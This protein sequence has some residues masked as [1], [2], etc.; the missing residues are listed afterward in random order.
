MYA[1]VSAEPGE[2]T[3]L[4]SPRNSVEGH[5]S[6]LESTRCNVL[7][8]P[9][10]SKV[11]HIL[12]KRKMRHFNV[13]GLAE[14]LRG[15]FIEHYEY[16][17]TFEEAERDPFIVVHT[18]G[19]TGLPK[20][21]IFYLGGMATIDNQHGISSLDGFDAQIKISEGPVRVFTGLPPFHV[22]PRS[23]HKIVC[24]MSNR[25]EH[26]SGGGY[27]TDSVNCP[28]FRGDDCLAARRS[29]Y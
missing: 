23:S 14:F 12:C 28:F 15:D 11:D 7:I 22:R 17:K 16:N 19:T 18:S 13:E 9:T 29:A 6:L 27:H 24:G 21:I 2:Q 5:L 8:S 26:L 10:E 1:I 3:L 25:T 4:S 20:P